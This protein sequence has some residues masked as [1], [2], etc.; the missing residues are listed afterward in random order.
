[1]PSVALISATAP[2]IRSGGSSSRIVEMP[3]GM[4]AGANP[5]SARATI[6]THSESLAAPS[7]EPARS[8][9]RETTIIRRLPYMSASRDRIGVATALVSRV[10]VTSQ[11]ALSMLVPSSR[12]KSGSSGTTSVCMSETAVPHSAST[13]TIGPARRVRSAGGTVGVV[14]AVN[15]RSSRHLPCRRP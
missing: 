9:S 6:R 14:V 7:R 15:G 4:S 12:G 13:R 1:M 10:T 3:I 5:C 11:E 2:P 8:T